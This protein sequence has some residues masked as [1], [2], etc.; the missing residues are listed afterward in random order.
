LTADP[1]ET[2]NQYQ[3]PQ[4]QE[5]IA[6]MK[7]ELLQLRQEAGDLSRSLLQNLLYNV[8]PQGFTGD[9]PWLTSKTLWHEV[10]SQLRVES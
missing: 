10:V 4:Y 6:Q 8:V 7:K 3:N 1:Y 5:V 2:R 9:P